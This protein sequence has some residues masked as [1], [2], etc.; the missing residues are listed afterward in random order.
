[1]K[2]LQPSLSENTSISLDLLNLYVVNQIASKA[3]VASKKAM[4]V[5]IKK[6]AIQGEKN[7]AELPMS[8]ITVPSKI[9]L[10]DSEVKTATGNEMLSMSEK[11]HFEKDES[12]ENQHQLYNELCPVQDSRL[13]NS[14]IKNYTDTEEPASTPS[15]NCSRLMSNGYVSESSNM[16]S[17]DE[18]IAAN[19]NTPRNDNLETE[20]YNT[21]V[22]SKVF[23]GLQQT[24]YANCRQIEKSVNIEKEFAEIQNIQGRHLSVQSNIPYLNNCKCETKLT[25]NEKQNAWSQTDVAYTIEKCHRAVQC[26]IV[27]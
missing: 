14:T 24:M 26:N 15:F 2:L 23:P 12:T 16:Q 27:K 25:I 13:Q 7:N 5:D 19:E 4:H 20:T 9:Y 3:D 21:E 17:D 10:A 22:G 11:L 18:D 6:P 1:M 8:P